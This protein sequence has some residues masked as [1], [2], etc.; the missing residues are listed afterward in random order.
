MPSR[1][2]HLFDPT[3]ILKD[4]Q[5]V[6]YEKKDHIAY[7]RFNRPDRLN[8]LNQRMSLEMYSIWLDASDRFSIRH[9][10]EVSGQPLQGSFN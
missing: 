1:N 5:H 6:V 7:I 2:P 8:S 4:L 3:P 10:Y 9:S